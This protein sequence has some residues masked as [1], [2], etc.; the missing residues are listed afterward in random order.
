MTKRFAADTVIDDISFSVQAG[1][2]VGVV[3]VNGSGKTTLMRILAGYLSPTKGKATIDGLDTVAF[4]LETR[5]RIGYLPESTG[6]CPGMRVDEFL[7]FRAAL[8]G[9]RRSER[10]DRVEEVKTLCGLKSAECRMIRGLS[11]GYRQRVGLADALVHDPK[12][13]MLDMPELGLD[14]DE[15]RKIRGLIQ[16]L[17]SRYTV[18]LSTHFLSEAQTVCGRVLVLDAGKIVAADSPESLAAST[19]GMALVAAEIFGPRND[20]AGELEKL[21]RARHVSF[22]PCAGQSA[23]AGNASI[24]GRYVVECEDGTETR[25]AIFGLAAGRRWP[26]RELRLEGRGLEEV[27]REIIVEE[28]GV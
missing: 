14:S 17:G 23:A 11:L 15:A 3:G 10:A 25:P 27:F 12:L 26:L 28:R 20:V 24:W 9:V 5:R 2:I 16:S 21:P 19:R 1:E 18:L 13:L 7:M 4:P 8:K 6:L 22:R